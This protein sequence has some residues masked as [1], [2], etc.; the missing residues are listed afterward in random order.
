MLCHLYDTP[1]LK[2][3]ALRLAG[4]EERVKRLLL[5]HGYVYKQLISDTPIPLSTNRSDTD[6]FCFEIG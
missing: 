6:I 1:T 5:L 4:K 3:K 2:T